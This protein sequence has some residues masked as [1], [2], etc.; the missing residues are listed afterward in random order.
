MTH[1]ELTPT[2]QD[3]SRDLQADLALCEEAT[4]GPW[5]HDERIRCAAIY[6]GIET[7]DCFDDLDEV[8]VFCSCPHTTQ[9]RTNWNMLAE[10]REGW[11]AAIRR[12]L[13]AEA[14]VAALRAYVGAEMLRSDY[15][16]AAHMRAELDRLRACVTALE[17]ER[18]PA[19]LSEADIARMVDEKNRLVREN[20]R[21]LARLA[22]RE[23]TPHDAS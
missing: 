5:L 12:A 22:E 11:P 20:N 10:S 3:R 2:D 18:V 9:S 14:E 7:I 1:P 16:T 23:D 13:A 17:A 8:V 19:R 15:Q 21:L 6:Q 4:P